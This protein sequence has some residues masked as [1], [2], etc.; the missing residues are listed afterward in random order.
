MI[1]AFPLSQSTVTKLLRMEH[2]LSH[3]IL[4][5]YIYPHMRTD[6]THG[7]ELLAVDFVNESTV[8]TR[9]GRNYDCNGISFRGNV[10]TMEVFESAFRAKLWLQWKFRGSLPCETVVTMRVSEG[11]FLTNHRRHGSVQTIQEHTVYFK[12]RL[13]SLS[14]NFLQNSRRLL[15][16]VFQA[17]SRVVVDL[18]PLSFKIPLE[19]LSTCTPRLSSF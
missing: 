4:N 3:Y 17:S 11:A 5:G 14:F 1:Q 15:P 18:Y 9:F 6:L 10:V 19:L 13:L 7:L 8:N 16:L 12:D 2:C